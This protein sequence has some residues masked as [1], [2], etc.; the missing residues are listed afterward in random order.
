MRQKGKGTPAIV[1]VRDVIGFLKVDQSNGLGIVLSFAFPLESPISKNNEAND[2][3][4]H[5]EPEEHH[6]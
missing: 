5:S 2:E 6:L 1:G 4:N 3:R